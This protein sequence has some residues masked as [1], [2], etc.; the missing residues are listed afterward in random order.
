MGP[1]SGCRPNPLDVAVSAL[2]T[3]MAKQRSSGRRAGHSPSL[4]LMGRTSNSTFLP[5][6]SPWRQRS[7]WR[8]SRVSTAGTSRRP[9]SRRSNS[10]QTD[11]NSSFRLRSRSNA[12]RPSRRAGAAARSRGQGRETTSTRCS[13]RSSRTAP[14]FRSSTSAATA[15]SGT[16]IKLSGSLGAVPSQDVGGVHRAVS[17]RIPG[18]RAAAAVVRH[19]G[20]GRAVRRGDQLLGAVVRLGLHSVDGERRDELRERSAPPP[21]PRSPW[22]GRSP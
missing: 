22:R 2:I 15:S 1:A 21:R 11:S 8:R 4:S 6:H 5:V 14:R 3:R 13:A 18:P 17:V 16:W 12:P 10:A 20:G 7:A 19:R 9:D